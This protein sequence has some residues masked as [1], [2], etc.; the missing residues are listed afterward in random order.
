MALGPRVVFERGGEDLAVAEI[1]V[2]IDGLL[3]LWEGKSS[4]A[5]VSLLLSGIPFPT[6]RVQAEVQRQ[7]TEGEDHW[8]SVEF[9]ESTLVGGRVILTP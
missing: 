5:E 4:P 2:R 8:S 1:V 6:P 7:Y 3:L 9:R